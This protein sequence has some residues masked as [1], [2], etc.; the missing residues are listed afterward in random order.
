MKPITRLS[1]E[2]PDRL[3]KKIKK[4]LLYNNKTVL[5]ISLIFRNKKFSFCLKSS[6]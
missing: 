4:S 2:C 6:L 5:V 3:L 1:F